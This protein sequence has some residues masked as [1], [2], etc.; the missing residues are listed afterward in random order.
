MCALCTALTGAALGSVG[1][2]QE[3]KTGDKPVAVAYSIK[4][5][6]AN[7]Y[8]MT[9]T[10]TASGTNVVVEQ[11]RKDTVTE[12]K[13]NGDTV[14]RIADLGGKV[15]VNG[16]EQ[17]ME[18]APGITMTMNKYGRVLSYKL[19]E[20]TQQYFTPQTMFLVVASGH[21]ILSDKPVKPGESWTTQMDDPLVKG[22]TITI[23]STFVGIERVDG[24]DAWRV[25]QTMDAPT[26]DSGADMTTSVDALLDPSTGRL[27][28]AD[29]MYK[30][31]P[32]TNGA[33]DWTGKAELIKVAAK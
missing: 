2:L 26:Q 21:P 4:T 6:D 24:A 16:T 1:A 17:E 30:S 3:P 31:V 23:K 20:D 28:K 15:T 11:N 10:I 18:P 5:G 7:R 25:K 22:K 19:D 27:I 8:R 12:I 13:P 9:M 33:V 32:T 14:T 29:E